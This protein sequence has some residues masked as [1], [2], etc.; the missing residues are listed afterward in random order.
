MTILVAVAPLR[1]VMTLSPHRMMA[2]S[3]RRQIL[4]SQSRSAKDGEA[5]SVLGHRIRCQHKRLL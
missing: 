1:L 2:L 4:M 3:Q 5:K